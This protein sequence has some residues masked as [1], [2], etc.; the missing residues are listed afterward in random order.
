MLLD[1]QDRVVFLNKFP[2]IQIQFLKMELISYEQSMFTK[3]ED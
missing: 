1:F 3:Y 2:D